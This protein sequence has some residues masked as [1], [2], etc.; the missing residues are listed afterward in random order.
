MAI[1]TTSLDQRCELIIDC[2]HS[3]PEW[4]EGGVVVLRSQNIKNG[5]LDLSSP[6]YTTEEG[7]KDR[8]KRAT[9][10]GGDLVITREAP[11]GEICRVPEGLRCC[12]GQRQVLI[13]PKSNSDYLHYAIQSPYV[14]KQ[15]RGHDSTGSTVSNLCIPDLKALR[16]PELP[17][18]S[19]IAKVLATIDAKIELNQ[20][21][22]AELE[23]MAKLLYD[24]WFV[25][26]DFPMT[27]AQAAALGKPKLAGHPYRASGGK[28]IYNET[29]KR[30]IPVGWDPDKLGNIVESISTGL[31]PRKHFT[32]GS[33][34]NYYVTIKS[35]E[36][37]KLLLDSKCDRIDDAALNRVNQ[38]S[39]LRPGDIL[40]TSI[41]PVGRLYLVQEMPR[42]WNINESLFSIRPKRDR[43]NSAF[44]YYL[45]SSH[46]CRG[47]CKK[48]STGSIHQG[49][50]IG[51]LRDYT[52]A[53]P[54]KQLLEAYNK[55]CE[56]TL[57]HTHILNQQ[58][59]ELTQLRDWLLPMLMNGQVTV[60]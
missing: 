9:P 35:I 32:L 12:L 55:L 36:H 26:F 33:G 17:N 10:R 4:T 34:S 30:D 11:M 59:Q 6:S 21:I 52:F 51:A 57:K 24:Y 1:K 58:T 23:G 50:R 13:R 56:P 42:N 60:G 44:L 28:M 19:G 25:Q 7:F 43:V 45:L 22:N 3:T 48:V 31:N 53:L 5:C 29:L 39:D 18:E 20:R 49:I 38:R 41:E 37:G 54:D 40:F 2:P 46:D 16:I 27:A 8:T 14:Q 15:I 47:Y